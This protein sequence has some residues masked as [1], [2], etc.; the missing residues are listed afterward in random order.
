MPSHYL[1]QCWN[2][3]N[4]VL[5]NKLQWNFNRNSNILIQEKSLENAV[6][7]MM[8]ILSRRQYVNGKGVFGRV[9]LHSNLLRLGV[10]T[11]GQ[12][13][14]AVL[15]LSPL[16]QWQYAV[17]TLSPLGQWWVKYPIHP[18]PTL[19]HPSLLNELWSLP[20]M[21]S[22][23]HL[24]SGVSNPSSPMYFNQTLSEKNH[25]PCFELINWKL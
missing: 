22:P 2:V 21:R 5:R 20:S 15:T 13:Q 9:I 10:G 19:P 3:V 7:E 14:Y 25:Y 8:P 12:W 24:D 18:T 11:T 23:A 4:W 16:G 17:L 6:C 1:N